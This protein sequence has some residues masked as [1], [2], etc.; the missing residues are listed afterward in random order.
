MIDARPFPWFSSGKATP[1]DGIVAL[2]GER[3]FRFSLANVDI[4][5]A[6]AKGNPAQVE[7]LVVV[8]ALGSLGVVLGLGLGWWYCP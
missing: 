4:T 1:R 3:H 8:V 2:T 6:A 5:F 7:V